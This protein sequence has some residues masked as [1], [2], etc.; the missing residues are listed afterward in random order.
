MPVH[1]RNVQ[2]QF[3]VPVCVG[4]LGRAS[5]GDFT[6]VT[7]PDA[8]NSVHTGYDCP[9]NSS[10]QNPDMSKTSGIY[11][12]LHGKQVVTRMVIESPN[13]A[14]LC[15]FETGRKPWPYIREGP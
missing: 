6:A 14:V 15:E 9:R 1:S 3:Y 13:S 4:S 11:G 8:D 12:L 5:V 2:F 10:P 7:T